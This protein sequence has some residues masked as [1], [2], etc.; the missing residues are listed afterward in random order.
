MGPRRFWHWNWSFC[1]LPIPGNALL[2]VVARHLLQ[3][4][5]SDLSF[6]SPSNTQSDYF[7]M[8]NYKQEVLLALLCSSSLLSLPH[9]VL[10]PYPPPPLSSGKFSRAAKRK[11]AKPQLS[12]IPIMSQSYHGERSLRRMKVPL[13]LTTAR[14][15]TSLARIRRSALLPFRMRGSMLESSR[16]LNCRGCILK[17]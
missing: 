4:L 3:Q 15:T 2:A 11:S 17:A 9:A 1:H 5:Q 7:P 6:A 10:T 16:V 8:I 12:T 13:L 14:L